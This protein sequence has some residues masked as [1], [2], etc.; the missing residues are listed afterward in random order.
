MTA[1]ASIVLAVLTLAAALAL[2]A[3][4]GR[5]PPGRRSGRAAALAIALLA[6]AA[7]AALGGPFWGPGPRA[8]PIPDTRRADLGEH[9]PLRRVAQALPPSNRGVAQRLEPAPTPGRLDELTLWL[10]ANDA[11]GTAAMRRQIMED[12]RRIFAAVFASDS[13]RHVQRVRVAATHPS[14]RGSR[15]GMEPTVAVVEQDRLRHRLGL[16]PRVRWLPPLQR[17]GSGP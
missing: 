1:F 17:S 2:A 8:R 4:A 10:A 16:A 7:L 9:D 6:G 14:G 13:L 3:G 12:C 15:P 5:L 11:P